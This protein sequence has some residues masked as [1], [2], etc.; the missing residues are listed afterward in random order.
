MSTELITSK[1]S[2]GVAGACASAAYET[3]DFY[4][5]C[6]LRCLGYEL[7]DLR[8]EGPAAGVRLSRQTGPA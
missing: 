6:F 1:R 7:L 8:P 3:R 4:L 2:E 5:A